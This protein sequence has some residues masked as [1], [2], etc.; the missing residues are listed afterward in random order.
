MLQLLEDEFSQEELAAALNVSQA[1]VSNWA[2]G[3]RSP[4]PEYA[5]R[6]DRAIAATD[7]QADIVDAGLRRGP[8][9]LPNALWEPVF[10]P[11]GRF[12]LPLHLEWS[13]TA[14]QRWRRADDLP[15]LLMAYVIVMTEGRVSDMIRWIDPKIL[16]AH[17]DE[18]IWPRGYEP[19][20]RAALEEW[21]LL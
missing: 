2:R 20:W 7:A 10:A 21:G 5:D 12:R 15:S 1:A 6:L 17:M 3:T 14:E 8:V 16:A 13:G 11:Q 18:V 9:R 4:Q 19:V